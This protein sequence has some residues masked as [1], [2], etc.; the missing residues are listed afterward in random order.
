MKC[1]GWGKGSLFATIAGL[2][3]GVF[4]GISPWLE[5]GLTAGAQ[6]AMSL[7]LFTTYLSIGMLV[8]ILPNCLG[9]GWF[10]GLIIGVAYSVP[11]SIFVTVPYPLVEDAPQYYKEFAAGGMRAF[12][13][14]LAFGGAV[15]LTAGVRKKRIRSGGNEE[16]P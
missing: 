1:F 14:T 6:V 16:N 5:E 12:W 7:G 2:A 15:G 8:A 4:A 9:P 3:W 13:L 10:F 11:G